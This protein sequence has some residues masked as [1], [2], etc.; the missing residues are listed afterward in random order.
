VRRLTGQLADGDGHLGRGEE[1]ACPVSV[2]EPSAEIFQLDL[3]QL[4]GQ[5][6]VHV[7]DPTTAQ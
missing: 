7:R 4:S 6:F 1:G 3:D 2:M 5:I